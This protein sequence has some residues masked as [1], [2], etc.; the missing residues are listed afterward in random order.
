MKSEKDTTKNFVT[1]WLLLTLKRGS[2]TNTR[3]A[4]PMTKSNRSPDLLTDEEIAARVVAGEKELYEIIMRRHNQRLFRISRAYVN[5]SN[6]AEDIVQ[7]AYIN[8]YENLPRFEGRSKFFTW[9]TRILINEALLRSK[10]RKRSVPLE[11]HASENGEEHEF[12][13]EE[14]ATE[15]N[16]AE[17]VMNDELRTILER[18]IDGLPTKYRSV[19]VMR[20]IDEMSIAETS[21]SLGISAANVKVR[22][23]R[24]KEVLKQRIGSVYHEAGV[25]HFDL[26]RCDRIVAN[27][28]ARVKRYQPPV[29]HGRDGQINAEGKR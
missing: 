25:Y 2:P 12:A 24:A 16:P 22:L 7:Q 23:N 8:A 20:E 28:L 9:L 1:F 15:E 17:K 4:S 29:R 10:Q 11:V 6:E 19:F 3:N 14:T 5:D 26:V 27:V 18:T 21:E 13:H